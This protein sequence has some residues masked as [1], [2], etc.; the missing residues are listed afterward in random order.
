MKQQK[1][2]YLC[3]N[4]SFLMIGDKDQ[5]RYPHDTAISALLE[6]GWKIASFHL[7]QT[8]SIEHDCPTGYVIVEK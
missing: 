1:L 6:A 5:E 7:A 3:G 2:V 8:K 4:G